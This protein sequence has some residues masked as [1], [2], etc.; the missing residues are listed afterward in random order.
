MRGH[1]MSPFRQMKCFLFAIRQSLMDAYKKFLDELGG[2]IKIFR[3]LCN[4]SQVE[5]A[6]KID[7]DK[8]TIQRIEN[9]QA[10]TTIPK[11]QKMAETFGIDIDMLVS[12]SRKKIVRKDFK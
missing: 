1:V 3:E 9:G 2:R 11:L 10:G 7:C 12:V 6:G 4:L 5:L 8:K